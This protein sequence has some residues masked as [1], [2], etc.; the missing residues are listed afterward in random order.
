MPLSIFQMEYPI[1]R[2]RVV[3]THL[4]LNRFFS[5]LFNIQWWT[6]TQVFEYCKRKRDEDDDDVDEWNKHRMKTKKKANIK[7]L[8]V[9][10]TLYLCIHFFLSNKQRSVHVAQNTVAPINLLQRNKIIHVICIKHLEFGEWR[11]LLFFC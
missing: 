11:T 1:P 8:S 5:F 9:C 3:M 6:V 4:T 7:K 10:I 2:R